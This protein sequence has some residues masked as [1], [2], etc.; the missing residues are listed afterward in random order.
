MSDLR[1]SGRRRL[2]RGPRSSGRRRLGLRLR[3]RGHWRWSGRRSRR[4][5]L[6]GRAAD[7]PLHFR[8]PRDLVPHPAQLPADA[9][10]S[11]AALVADPAP[12]LLGVL[13][14]G[15][16]HFRL[17]QCLLG[18]AALLIQTGLRP[19][20]PL[21]LLADRRGVSPQLLDDAAEPG[22]VVFADAGPD[23]GRRLVAGGV[24]SG[25]PLL[26]L[27]ALL[28]EAFDR[29]VSIRGRF[30]HDGTFLSAARGRASGLGSVDSPG[31]G[32]GQPGESRPRT[33]GFPCG[34]GPSQAGRSPPAPID[35]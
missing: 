20:M 19:A 7:E 34:C 11:F 4:F 21:E 32:R 24:Q 10:Q 30:G 17:R 13:P 25:E 28:Q 6:L 31:R 2:R 22:L 9:T 23:R 12:F 26:V 35:P 33:P 15:V 29:R 1:L 5:G 14:D 3:C 16:A 18:R 27:G 8:Q